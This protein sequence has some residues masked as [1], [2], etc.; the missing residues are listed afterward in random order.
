LKKEKE[1][2]NMA[3]NKV[4][5]TGMRTA[6]NEIEQMANEYT[7]QV[8]ALYSAGRELDAMWD[9]DAS[10]TF[11]AQLGQDQPRFDALNTVVKQYAE[12]LR[13]NADSYDRAEDEAVQTLRSNT[14][15]RT[16]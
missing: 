2:I 6:A 3:I 12:T 9:G 5:T 10:D 1:E 13:S 8:T 16:G 15:R 11:K 7:Q 14:V 4:N